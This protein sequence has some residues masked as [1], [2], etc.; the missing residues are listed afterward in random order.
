MYF[1][2]NAMIKDMDIFKQTKG[3]GLMSDYPNVIL[4]S[5]P[6]LQVA[7]L[8]SC[9]RVKLDIPVQQ[10]REVTELEDVAINDDLL[11]LVDIDN[12]T[13]ATQEQLKARLKLFHGCFRLALINLEDETTM[14]NISTWPSIFGVFNKS[15]ELDT[16]CKGIEK[17]IEGEFWM[18]RQ[19][20]SSL[21]SIYRS[22]KSIEREKK[23]ELTI[24]EQEILRQL[25]TGASN[26]EIAD[27][28]YV[29]E[30]TIKSH[31]YNVFKKIKV[32]NRL[33]AVSWA[34]DSLL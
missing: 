17:I 14:E 3:F 32:K 34:K 29:S 19:T 15:D 23:P 5:Q 26:S 33:Q 20:L 2:Y 16:V 11:L 18:P 30:H 31:L 22:E 4:L 24:R 8:V 28:L 21:I 7:T 27:T 12:L 6:S 13:P 1:F 10:I 9:L 25:M